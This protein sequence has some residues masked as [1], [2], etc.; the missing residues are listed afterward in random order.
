MSDM[1]ELIE[2]VQESIREV[3]AAMDEV[4]LPRRTLNPCTV[5]HKALAGLR[6][7]VQAHNTCTEDLLAALEAG[8]ART[9]VPPEVLQR[10]RELSGNDDSLRLRMPWMNMAMERGDVI[11]DLLPHLRPEAAASTPDFEA[12]SA[13]ERKAW[14]RERGR[15]AVLDEIG[16][17]AWA[18]LLDHDKRGCPIAT[19]TAVDEPAALLALCE[20]VAVKERGEDE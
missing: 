12:M 19:A 14:L 8:D 18:R 3:R 5:D 7:A 16:G 20:A 15:L 6:R 13:D 2:L 10:A 17:S 4:P 11:R 9:P 1:Q